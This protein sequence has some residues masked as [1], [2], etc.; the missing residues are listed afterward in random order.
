MSQ[1]RGEVQEELV[2]IG[3]I[4]GELRAIRLLQ[5]ASNQNQEKIMAAIDTLNQADTDLKDEVATFIADWQAALT[6]AS[7]DPAVL[8]VAQDMENTV[9]QLK[10]SDPATAATATPVETAT[11]DSSAAA[12]S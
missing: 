4:L 7:N 8:A 12:A 9:A 6:A 1:V 5:V 10:A 2:T 3:E 11:P